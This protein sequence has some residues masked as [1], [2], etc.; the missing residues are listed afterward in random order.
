[1]RFLPVVLLPLALT[2]CGVVAPAPVVPSPAPST[3]LPQHCVPTQGWTVIMTADWLRSNKLVAD[4]GEDFVL[5]AHNPNLCNA[6]A[7]TIE[8]FCSVAGSE[9]YAGPD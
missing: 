3:D 1:M 8:S 7:I 2:A 6:G 5:T 9:N 4:N